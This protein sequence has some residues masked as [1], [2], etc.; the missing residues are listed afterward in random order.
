MVTIFSSFIHTVFILFFIH[1]SSC[2][3][4]FS[5]LEDS[6]DLPPLGSWSTLFTATATHQ[7]TPASGSQQ[8]FHGHSRRLY[9]T[10]SPFSS[11]LKAAWHPWSLQ[12][13]AG[14]LGGCYIEMVLL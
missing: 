2:I 12:A 8:P 5:P 13:A 4:L 3:L 11:P 1:T 6:A 14:S 9:E 7:Y 10:L